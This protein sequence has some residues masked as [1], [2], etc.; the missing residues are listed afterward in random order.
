[1][2]LPYFNRQKTAPLVS[3]GE[4]AADL[5]GWQELADKTK[6]QLLDLRVP[7]VYKELHLQLVLD[8]DQLGRAATAESESM[9]ALQKKIS[10]LVT[11]YPWLNQ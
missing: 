2:L 8:F 5:A 1:L 10:D 4:P 11:A 9:V 7:E 3:A 6:S